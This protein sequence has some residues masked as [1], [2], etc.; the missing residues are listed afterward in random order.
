MSD[1]RQAAQQALE[2]LD[3][4]HPDIQ[5]RA[6]ITLRAALAQPEQKPVAWR[7]QSKLGNGYLTEKRA[8]ASEDWHETPL[9]T[10]PPT[11]KETAEPVAWIYEYTNFRREKAIGFYPS[12]ENGVICTPVYAAPPQRKP[13]TEAQIYEVLGYG[14]MAQYNSVPQYAMECVRAIEKAHG[15]GEK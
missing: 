2:A 12:A 15:I 14:A 8:E 9:Y 3:S 7:Y 10:A 6:A 11:P 5:L 1:L 13:L 4:D